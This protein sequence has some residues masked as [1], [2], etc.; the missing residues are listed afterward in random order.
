MTTDEKLDLILETLKRIE[1]RQKGVEE[2]QKGLEERQKV[3]K[4]EV[5]EV[6]AANPVR[7]SFA[8]RDQSAGKK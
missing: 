4:Q 2:R 8:S 1:E 7:G 5:E 3:I 6:E